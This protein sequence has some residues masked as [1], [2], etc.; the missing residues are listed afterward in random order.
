MAWLARLDKRAATWN[1]PARWS[2]LAVK[3]YLAASGAMMAVVLAVDE[4]KD[5]RA[6]LGLGIV[7][8]LFFV[9]IAGV[10]GAIS[11]ARNQT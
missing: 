4:L 9:A 3:W 11:K 10:L 2:Y 5:G 8:T 6:G 1:R 7:V